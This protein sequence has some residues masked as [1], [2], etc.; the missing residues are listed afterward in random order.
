MKKCRVAVVLAVS[1]LLLPQLLQAAEEQGMEIQTNGYCD[2]SVMFRCGNSSVY[3][4]K[5]KECDRNY[6]CKFG[7][8][9]KDCASKM[10]SLLWHMIMLRTDM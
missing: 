7:E 5:E 1:V 3:I 2:I 9:E 6:D 8:D 4:G 10:T